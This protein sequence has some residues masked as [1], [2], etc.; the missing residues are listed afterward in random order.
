MKS[1]LVFIIIPTYNRSH[2]I[3]ATLDSMLAQTHNIW[4]YTKEI[5][6]A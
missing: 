2:L 5:T 4:K 6:K 3:G 1:L